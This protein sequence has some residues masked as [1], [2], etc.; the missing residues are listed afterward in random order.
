M[1]TT[2]D[3]SA[4]IATIPS[5][6]TSGSVSA[7]T[8]NGAS[9]RI[10]RTR[11]SI[12]SATP[13]KK[14]TTG[15]RCSGATY[16]SESPNAKA[17]TMRGSIAPSAALR[18]GLEGTRSVIHCVRLGARRATSTPPVAPSADIAFARSTEVAAGSM[19]RCEKTE[20]PMMA[21]ASVP[22]ASEETPSCRPRSAPP[23][24]VPKL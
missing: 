22:H 9:T 18:T 12:A 1:S 7:N 17:K 16:K 13:R 6:A 10:Q 19:A 5:R 14:R 4:P 21:P 23:A 20:G 3:A 11:R 2:Y 8:P 24:I 15:S